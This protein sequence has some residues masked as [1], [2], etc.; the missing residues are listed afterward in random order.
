VALVLE[1]LKK[2]EQDRI[3]TQQAVDAL[4]RAGILVPWQP[5][6]TPD[7]P[8]T[9]LYRIDTTAFD[10]LE[11]DVFLSLKKARSLPL[12]YAHLFSFGQVAVLKKRADR[13]EVA[14]LPPDPADIQTLFGDD[15][16]TIIG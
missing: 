1:F 8:E 13:A 16:G 2:I 15:D 14:P 6:E 11:D 10:A 4:D 7:K 12:V 3:L 9:G 5:T